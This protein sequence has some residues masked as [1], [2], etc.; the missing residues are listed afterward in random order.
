M[1]PV[2]DEQA[3][4][5]TRTVTSSGRRPGASA[6]ERKRRQRERDQQPIYETEDWR[7]FTE[8]A[9]LP[10]KAGCQPAYLREIVLKELVDNAP[11]AGARVSLD[12]AGDIWIVCDD[13]PGLDPADVPRLFCVNRPLRSSKLRRHRC[14]ACWVT[15]CG[16]W[17]ALSLHSRAFSLSRPVAIV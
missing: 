11:D 4:L 16:L 15:D 5:S 13:G 17:S 2:P 1:N 9:A 8:L 10:Q 14:A 12:H 6:T 3:E 7:L